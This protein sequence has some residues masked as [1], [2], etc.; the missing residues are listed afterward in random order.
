[1]NSI[2]WFVAGTAVA[3]SGFAQDAQPN[4]AQLEQALQST[5]QSRTRCDASFQKARDELVRLDA[6]VEKQVGELVQYVSG[7]TDSTESGTEI[8]NL[9]EDLL[10]GL[11]NSLAWYKRERDERI[12]SMSGRSAI[13]GADKEVGAMDERIDRRISEML[14]VTA[15]LTEHKDFQKYETYY[16]TQD[17][18]YHRQ[19]R[20]EYQQSRRAGGKSEDLKEDLEGDL[21]KGI[22]QLEQ[23]EALLQSKLQ[24]VSNTDAAASVEAELKWVRQ[25]LETRRTQMRTLLTQSAIPAA[26]LGDKEASNVRRRVQEAA[27]RIKNDWRLMQAAEIKYST[28]KQRLHQIDSRIARMEK[29][30]SALP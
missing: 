5:R 26:E 11:G 30:L 29:Q 10:K 4:R 18:E 14:A 28:E 2:G 1:M 7:V 23:K 8:A 12:L 15:S 22:A 27:Q 25:L 16:N 13:E 19:V 21:E 6:S 9:K 24:T 20:D 3:L 17:D